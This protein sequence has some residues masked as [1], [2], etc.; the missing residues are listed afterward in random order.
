MQPKINI[1][2]SQSNIFT[3]KRQESNES[4]Q[5]ESACLPRPEVIKRLRERGHPILLYG[6][7]E[8]QAFRRLR[9]IE[10]QEPEANKVSPILGLGC[11]FHFLYE[12][13]IIKL[14]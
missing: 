3:A 14:H 7:S 10:I 11:A 8:I 6:E 9:R 13:S 5:T 4:E 12:N 2:N 1:N